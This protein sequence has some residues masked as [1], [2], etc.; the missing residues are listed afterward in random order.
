MERFWVPHKELVWA[1]CCLVGSDTG[2]S[3]FKTD[4][5]AVVTVPGP[6]AATLYKVHESHLLGIDN[7]CA[8]DN[9]TEGALLH[10]VRVRY[11]RKEIYTRVARILIAVNPFQSM[12][13]YTSAYADRYK[14][15]NDSMELEP[16]VYGVGL[17]AVLAMRRGMRNQAVLISGESGA[18]KTE[19]TKLV[20]SFTAEA[21]SGSGGIQEKIMQTSPVLE[22]FGNAMTVR[23][24]NSS[25]FGKWLEMTVS[26]T[27]QIDGCSVTDYL[28]EVT[29]VCSQG[30]N[31]RNYHIFFQLIQ[32]RCQK[33]M[34]DMDI[35][36]PEEYRYLQGAKTV[37]PGINDSDC[38][39]EI[40]EAFSTLGIEPALQQEIFRIVIGILTIGNCDF[41]DDGEHASLSSEAPVQKAAELL[42]VDREE[43]RNA[44]LVK[45]IVVCKEVTRSPLGAKAAKA[46]R[47]GLARL[48]YGRI[49]KWL[50]ARVNSALSEGAKSTQYFGVLD[51]AGFECFEHNSL[52]Q[53]FINLSNE[54][55]QQHFNNHVFKME[56]DD[57]KSEGVEACAGLTYQDNGEI[58]QLVDSK[59][60]IL[61][62]LDEEVA[63]PKASD[64]TFIAKVLKAHE[65]HPRLVVPKFAG[66][67]QFGIRH[68]PGEVTYSID[69]FLEKNIDKPPDDAPVLF[70]ASTLDV[71]RQVSKM[72]ALEVAEG[73]GGKKKPKTVSAGFRSS[74]ALLVEKLN[75]AEPHFIRCVKPNAEKAPDK[76]T[77]RL[78]I[79]QLLFSGIMEAIRIRQ[80]G[81]A[82]RTPFNEFLGRYRCVAP[83]ATRTKLWGPGGPKDETKRVNIF[84]EALPGSLATVGSFAATD[85]VV[86]KTKVFARMPAINALDRAREI[87]LSGHAVIIQRI[88]KGLLV[89][90]M[91][92]DVMVVLAELTAWLNNNYFYSKRGSEHTALHK[93]KTPEAIDAQIDRLSKILEKTDRLPVC[94]PSRSHI[95][96]VQKRM[97]SEAK[98]VRQM[99]GLLDAVDPIKIEEALARAKDLEI[100]STADMQ[101]LEVRNKQLKIQLPLVKAMQDAL[102]RSDGA[103][104]Q[105]CMESVK[106]HELNKNPESW[107]PELKG[108]ELSG[109]IFDEM[110]RKKAKKRLD[111]IEAKRKAEVDQSV[112]QQQ[113]VAEEAAFVVEEEKP[114]AQNR[115]S[116]PK[117][118]TIT[119]MSVREQ[120][121]ILQGLTVASNEFDVA[122]LEVKLGEAL[123]GG[124]DPSETEEAQELLSKLQTEEF[125]CSSMRELQEKVEWECAQEKV[126][127][128][129]A[130]ANALKSLQN[131]V[132]QAKRLGV[133]DERFWAAEASLQRG[134][135]KRA[136]ATLRGNIFNFVDLSEIA[137]AEE[138]FADLSTFQNLKPVSQWQGHR[139]ENWLSRSKKGAEVMLVHSKLEIR[140]ALTKVTPCQEQGSVQCFRNLL[141][142]MSDRAIPMSQRLGCSREIVEFAKSDP[143]VADEVFVQ[144]MKQLTKNPS[145]R[146][147]L[148]GW[149]VM[150]LVCQHTHPSEALEEF[151]RAF[152]MKSLRENQQNGFDEAVVVAK[153]CCLDL[154]A[155]YAA[156]EVKQAMSMHANSDPMVGQGESPDDIVPLQVML[157]DHSTRKVHAPQSTTLAGLGARMSE[158][159]GLY[160]PKDFGFFQMTDG[161]ESH[162]LLPN[163][164]VLST[165]T[166]KWE[167][168]KES[169]GRTSHLL[170]K[171]RF[172]R[173]DEMLQAGDLIHATLTYRQALW[174]YLHY[175]VAE[176]PT[177]ICEIAGTI[178]CIEA[179]HY[180]EHIQQGR[181]HEE[182]ILEHLLPEYN[183]RY[184]K[185]QVWARQV[186]D[187]F[188]RLQKSW[189]PEESRLQKMSRLMSL[190]QKLKLF[191]AHYWYGRQIHDVPEEKK[192]MTDV[193]SQMC[194][195]NPK[196]PEAD[197]WI[198]VDLFGVRFVSVD[199]AVGTEFQRGFLFNEE[200]VERVLRWGAKQ[201]VVQFVVQTVNPSLPS[202]G[203]VPMT[204]ALTS[205]AAI[206]ISYAVHMINADRKAGRGGR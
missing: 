132:Q 117:R 181:L 136:R 102:D 119:G 34:K 180:A 157:I 110:E 169:T 200:A 52:E 142:W 96:K 61:S 205:P 158:Q 121:Q 41:A 85:I 20:L 26:K 116:K 177:Y 161:L 109:R 149:K 68:F 13:I 154:N 97:D 45:K 76:I 87:A 19:S 56:L 174:D 3:I 99:K 86:G 120:E 153:Q 171:R 155:H 37:A 35:K 112:L 162:R 90:R 21:I 122:S 53:L 104:L 18:G 146:S 179:D 168:L 133:D 12:S 166:K 71:L 89:R 75:D 123:T 78:V 186:T 15:A 42:G 198:C 113:K 100:S 33:E 22:A 51:I 150:L 30:P 14:E 135:R 115:K 74:L 204:I 170:W 1:P 6:Q 144:M 131:L 167:R 81:F 130:P 47:D 73:G 72:I 206:D 88:Y 98:V 164:A 103:R 184:Q 7:I 91:M 190:M 195:I 188:H 70:G 17:D 111:D 82:A 175:P 63:M 64:D 201:N 118:P 84:V 126:E 67:K 151:V 124:I 24:N 160:H 139:R 2:G 29:R 191:G 55:L 50:I 92:K 83:K 173:V 62:I 145:R 165:L 25:R 203:R 69:G 49:F 31:E 199:S 10:T 127:S 128:E 194:K 39:E 40:K 148:L 77:S 60:G 183:L 28:L 79:E 182:G 11:A 57:Y 197:Y 178:L 54:H 32:A 36:A 5:G 94:K 141:G 9:V 65:K 152:H 189:D 143:A 156:P 163:S 48:L 172:M 176:D 23:N 193:P 43:L 46:A 59:G 129:S 4:D 27:Q 125:I 187:A 185:R 114:E 44:M 202:A 66:A 38:F 159:L 196:E 105:E 106:T 8:L 58:L 134:V 192:S 16:H 101:A 80:A 138:T 108:M 95:L 140:M 93:W 107:L 137:L 147:A